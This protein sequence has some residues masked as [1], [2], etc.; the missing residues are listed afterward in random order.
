MICSL[1]K[2]QAP[3]F[4]EQTST[5]CGDTDFDI[6]AAQVSSPLFRRIGA[7]YSGVLASRE[8]QAEY[9]AASSEASALECDDPKP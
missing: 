8:S 4:K 6:F 2:Y 9:A 7:A 3:C 5:T 1:P